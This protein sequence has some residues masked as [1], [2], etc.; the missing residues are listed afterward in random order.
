MDHAWL[1]CMEGNTTGYMYHDMNMHK[2]WMGF[3]LLTVSLICICFSIVP[4]KIDDSV[5]N[6]LSVSKKD[7]HA[8]KGDQ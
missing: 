4:L 7:G 5:K 1:G 6:L 3:T 8:N 2:Q